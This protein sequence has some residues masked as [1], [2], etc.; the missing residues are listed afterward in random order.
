MS[1]PGFSGNTPTAGGAGGGAGAGGQGGGTGG[2]GGTQPG[3][4]TGQGGG[5]Q[6]NYQELFESTKADLGKAQGELGR[7]RQTISQLSKKTAETDKTIGALRNVFAPEQQQSDPTEDRLSQLEAELDQVIATGIEYE[8]AG[9]PI[10]VTVRNAVRS[11]EFQ[12]EQEKRNR[13]LNGELAEV[14]KKLDAVSNPDVQL[15]Q[16]AGQIMD[17]ALMTALDT[18]YGVGD[19]LGD[20]KVAQWNAIIQQM[21]AEVKGLKREK[22]ELWNQIRRNPQKLHRLV[23]H[24]I[25]KNMP[26]RARQLI[27]Q[28]QLE[29]EPVTMA[30][31]KQAYDEA[32]AIQDPR[33]RNAWMTKIRQEILAFTYNRG[34]N[35]RRGAGG[36][37][38]RR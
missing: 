34:S 15:D 29:N 33:E 30:D 17:D 20:T 26:P 38:R 18:V 2:A 32:K 22:P 14:K 16:R 36:G 13:A 37:G 6:I 8:K 3:I 7:Q 12:I 19:E 23:N 21:A 9:R 1:V 25:T 35:E 11:L 31:L 4:P 5:A 27:E 10:N 28:E 24:F